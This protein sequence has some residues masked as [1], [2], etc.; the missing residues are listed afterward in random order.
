MLFEKR[1]PAMQETK[2]KQKFSY[3]LSFKFPTPIDKTLLMIS[4]VK[5]K[6]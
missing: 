3:S 5:E 2:E 1:A 4:S 6:S